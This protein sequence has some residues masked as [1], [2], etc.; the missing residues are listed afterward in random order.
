MIV[1]L[2]EAAAGFWGTLLL[3]MLIKPGAHGV[4]DLNAGTGWYLIE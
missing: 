3:A 1:V 4:R 2:T